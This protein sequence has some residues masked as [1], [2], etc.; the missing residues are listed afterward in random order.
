[1]IHVSVP[2]KQLWTANAK[3]ALRGVVPL[4]SFS[5]LGVLG[6]P[7]GTAIPNSVLNPFPS[8][9]RVIKRFLVVLFFRRVRNVETRAYA[10][11]RNSFAVVAMGVLIF[12][13]ATAL[14]QAQNEIGTRTVSD[15]CFFSARTHRLSILSER[16]IYDNRWNTSLP[17]DVNITISVV[18]SN[19]SRGYETYNTTDC[20]FVWSKMFQSELDYRFYQ[21]RTLELF[22]CSMDPDP[23]FDYSDIYY[24][25]GEF[26]DS[27]VYRV[28]A[29]PA[30]G[31]SGRTLFDS[32]MPRIWLVN[33]NHLNSTDL[34]QSNVG[35]VRTYLPPFKLLRGSHIATE[36]NLVTRRL[37]ESSIV[38]DII[39]QSKPN[40]RILSLYP[41][42][43][44]SVAMLNSSDANAA[45]ATIRPTLNPGLMYHRSQANVEYPDDPLRNV[46]DFVDDYRT[47]TILDVIG[48]VGGLFALL[49]AAHLLLFGRPLFWGLT[50]TK[51]I[52][53][54]GLLGG[55]SSGGFK[56]RLREEYHSKSDEDDTDTIR[57]VKF[58]QD[59]VIDF[60]P[61]DLDL[62]GLPAKEKTQSS[63]TLV[64]NEDSV[65]SRIP[66][67]Q[68]N[69]DTNDT[70]QKNND[71][72]EEENHTKHRDSTHNNV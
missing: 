37:I 45:T 34:D 44:S 25:L 13:T 50:G 7:R 33:R 2:G 67:V 27:Y 66:L 58:L 30:A 18:W 40:H 15:N 26:S 62:E 9:A 65:G 5:D 47:G 16:L 14:Q 4:P 42:L 57:I 19:P 1:M 3:D 52:T 46:C 53:P 41:I 63:P 22:D 36:A 24:T 60:G 69:S 61:A 11:A 71:A 54:F 49:Q 56:R 10:F 43:K 20:N 38:R 28:E 39:F 12:R 68:M 64:A 55:C 48:S 23:T 17:P 51:T 6:R 29:R 70:T 35:E 21:N 59:F 31:T 32:Q 72:E 8:I